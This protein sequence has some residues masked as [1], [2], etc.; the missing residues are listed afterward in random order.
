MRTLVVLLLLGVASAQAAGPAGEALPPLPGIHHDRDSEE[1]YEIEIQKSR[2]RLVRGVTM[3]AKFAGKMTGLEKVARIEARRHVASDGTINYDVIAREGDKTVQKELIVRFINLE[4]EARSHGGEDVAITPKNYKLKF[5]GSIDQAGRDT[6]IFEVHPRKKR[7]GLFKGEVWVDTETGLTVHQ[8][9][10]WVK[11]PSVFVKSVKFV[12][13]F[14]IRDGYQVPK[15]T[16][17]TTQTRFWGVA[18]M[19]VEYTDISW[20]TAVAASQSQN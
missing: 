20:D 1:R 11:S 7:I 16:S 12:Q 8:A 4:M 3:V 19:N 17:F 6:D 10:Q 13:D 5:K 14:E 18:E 9:G 2:N 15:S